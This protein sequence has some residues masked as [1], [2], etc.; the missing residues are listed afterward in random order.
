MR[1]KKT[2]LIVDDESVIALNEASLLKDWGYK[3][4]VANTGAE[5]IKAALEQS[6]DL[7]LMDIDLGDE[8]MDGPTAARMILEDQD[9]PVIFLSCRTEPEILE[10]AEKVDSYG[11]VLK[12]SSKDVL[13][14][15]IK[16]A[17]K[18]HK[19]YTE[20]KRVSAALK[21]SQKA[22]RESEQKFRSL[23]ENTNEWV[24]QVDTQGKYC[25][26]SSNAEEIT[27]YPLSEIYGKTPFEFMKPQEAQRVLGM[28]SKL[29]Q[30]HEQIRNLEDTMIRK[31]G[32][33]VIFET[34]ATPLYDDA[35][36]LRGYFGTCRDIT[37][38]I[39]MEE[40]I[41]ESERQKNVILN[42][43][44]EMVAYY[45]LDFSV[46]WC[47]QAAAVTA[48]KYPEELIGLRCYEVWKGRS[49][50]CPECPVVK[51]RET[52]TPQEGEQQTPD[53]RSWL[54]RGYPVLDE[55][56]TVTALVEFGQ[57][58]TEQKKMEK[59]LH[60]SLQEKNS[61]M[62][63][64]N[65][66]VKNNLMQITSLINLKNAAL[67]E[68]VDLY[69]IIHQ[70]DAIRIVHEKL[71]T[72]GDITHISIREYLHDLLSTVFA[73]FVERPVEIIDKIEEHRIPTKTAIPIGLITNEIATNAI[74][75]G[76]PGHESPRFTV[77]FRRDTVSGTQTLILSNTGAPFP[78]DI[79]FDNPATLGLRLI[80]ALAEQL[81]GTVELARK[82]H[83]LLT[84]RFPIE[85]N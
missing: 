9:I 26:V 60:R 81:D 52:K 12:A 58:I 55:F 39:K 65:H 16:I 40:T 82:P 56:G 21:E 74:K 4:I 67:G 14:A 70:I 62:Q 57:N 85:D 68:S 51:A 17:F 42:S 45:D 28:F 47:N 34:N 76:F 49:N 71:Y 37:D 10:R 33:P 31:D 38:R 5:G 77:A 75:Y 61:L 19:A 15:S 46:I 69:D 35:G 1:D 84:I 20:E 78:E 30:N 27:G 66:R 2:L 50:P 29:A 13:H 73:S 59:N 11:Y 80:S 48:G 63:E 23:V 24:W 8:E 25:Y 3:V 53:G 83:P 54:V 6:I 41:E 32:T 22:L 7:I 79:D 18:L 44:S 72:T 43:T 64:L 36:A